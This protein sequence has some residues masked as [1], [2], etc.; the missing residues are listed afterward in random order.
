MDD[1]SGRDSAGKTGTSQAAKDAL[2][3]GFTADYVAGVWMGY[4]NNTPL[5]GVTG[6]GLP[7]EIWHAAMVLAH[8]GL[9]AHVLPM[10]AP[11]PNEGRVLSSPSRQSGAGRTQNAIQ[12]LLQGIFGKSEGAGTTENTQDRALR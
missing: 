2:F 4:D 5:S 10:R 6:S 3:I 9:P 7:A 1:A 11:D 12:S 8:E